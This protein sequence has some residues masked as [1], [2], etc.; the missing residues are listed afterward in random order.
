MEAYQWLLLVIGIF[1]F[2]KVV[3]NGMVFPR[4]EKKLIAQ[5]QAEIAQLLAANGGKLPAISSGCTCVLKKGEILHSSEQVK[6]I[7]GVRKRRTRG[8]GISTRL[9]RSVSFHSATAYSEGYDVYETIDQ[10]NLAI[11]NKRIVFTGVKEN[12]VVNLEKI[13]SIRSN[14]RQ[15]VV[16]VES[17]QKAL[18]FEGCD[19][20]HDNF[21]IQAAMQSL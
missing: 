15:L 3:I 6:L 1:L 4:M 10:G 11:T 19:G 14:T 18:I 20:W 5:K 2:W 8:S 9:S 17:R 21:L 16:M 7:E 12:R 13:I